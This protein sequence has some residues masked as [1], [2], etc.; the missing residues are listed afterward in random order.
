MVKQ[1]YQENNNHVLVGFV[2]GRFD[3]LGNVAYPTFD[4][5]VMKH[6]IFYLSWFCF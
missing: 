4:W 5:L 1:I 6:W 3:Q 2:F